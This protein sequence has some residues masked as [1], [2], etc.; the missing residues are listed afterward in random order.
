MIVGA[1]VLPG[2]TVTACLIAFISLG[3]GI[4][5]AAIYIVCG[6]DAVAGARGAEENKEIS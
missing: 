1:F 3:N 6:A 2:P 5:P 4:Q